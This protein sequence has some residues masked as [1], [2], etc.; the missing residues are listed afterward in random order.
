MNQPNLVQEILKIRN[1]LQ[2]NTIGIILGDRLNLDTAAAAL[3]LYLSLSEAGKNPQIISKK[4]PTVE[5]ANLVGINKIKKSFS[6][7][8]NRVVVSLPYNRGEIGKVSYKEEN[9]RINFYLTAAEG[10]SISQYDTDAINLMWDGSMPSVM[11]VFGV[12]SSSQL[13]EYVGSKQSSIKVINI[14]NS[15]E[16]F[17]DISIADNSF[18]SVSE[19][20]SRVIKELRLPMNIDIAQ[21][22]LDGILFSTRN[23]TKPNSSFYAFEATGAMMQLGAVRQEPR[24]GGRQ[25]GSQNRQSQFSNQNRNQVNQNRSNNQPVQNVNTSNQHNVQ[26]RNVRVDVS[27][28][29]S[30]NQGDS[31]GQSLNE[32]DSNTDQVQESQ[33]I[34]S[35][36][37]MPKV[38][39]GSQNADDLK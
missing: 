25:G 18:S 1:L 15:G 13:M 17:G 8:S 23:F 37:L 20:V 28:I 7:D 39:K 32:V 16:A 35:D 11:F 12:S 27:K 14:D 3:G 4:E 21:N 5:I 22:L 33:D 10:K 36:W 29:E 2:N 19:I 34:P 26:D 9:D 38:F 31:F 6:G 24:S 30:Q